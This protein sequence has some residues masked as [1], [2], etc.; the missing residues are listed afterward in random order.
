[1]MFK[2]FSLWCDFI[3]RAFLA[4]EFA[5]YMESWKLKGATSNPVIFEHALHNPSY[6]N[7]IERLKKQGNSAKAIYESLAT[8]DIKKAAQILRPLY[9][10]N[11]QN[12]WVSIEI[13][14]FLCDDVAQS[15]DEGRRLF[16]II[17]E[18]NVMLKVPA[19]EAGYAVMRILFAEG[20]SVNATLVFS[21]LQAMKIL[22]SLHDNPQN[23]QAVVSVFVSRFDRACANLQQ[24][25]MLGITNAA[26][27]HKILQTK[28]PS[29]LRTLFASTGV[30]GE[31]LPSDYYIRA[32]LFENCINTAP[33]AALQAFANGAHS[34]NEQNDMIASCSIDT[35]QKRMD[36]FGIDVGA[37]SAKLFAQ[38]IAAFKDSF[39]NLLSRLA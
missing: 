37:L 25:P 6:A 17:D 23:A 4:E 7:D 24:P 21:P 19:T 35:L 28:A 15:V 9:D 14:P 26:W 1:M 30:K 16:R 3:E 12:G 22:E 20:I 27:I 5:Q 36:S 29:Y 2:T 34:P 10:V 39:T 13:D 33:L 31:E 18:P 32:L 38:G 8:A 11:P